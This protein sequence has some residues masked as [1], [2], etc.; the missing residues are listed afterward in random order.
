[1]KTFPAAL[2]AH[3]DSGATTLCR[4]WR[5]TRADAVILGF[6]DHDRDVTCDG[7]VFRAASGFN[8]SEIASSLGLAIDNFTAEG[9]L[10]SDAIFEEDI[11]A[12]RY[13]NAA[14][15]VLRVNW[16]DPTQ[17]YVEARGSVGNIE[18]RGVAFTAEFRSLAAQLNQRAGRNFERSCSAELGDAACGVNLANPLYTVNAVAAAAAEGLFVT[19]AGFGSF[20]RGWFTG[21]LL[22]VAGA[23]FEIKSHKLA[24]DGTTAVFEL[25][26]AP[27]PPIAAGGAFTVIA[28]CAKNFAAC[29]SKFA[30]VANFQGFP[31]IPV[32]DTIS[33]VAKR[34]DVQNT[35]G[36]LFG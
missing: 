19:A 25:W 20:R 28:G 6:T 36:S 5:V 29:K 4:C 26:N 27:S 9:G 31:H 23:D 30:N 22:R 1:M 21:G 8:A 35:G 7:A 12:G 2:A 34:G 13:D 16:A 17:F 14:I 24:P 33:K 18:R 32:S 10:S 11:L 15:D 3:I